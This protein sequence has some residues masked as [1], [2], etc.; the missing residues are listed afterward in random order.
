M[1]KNTLRKLNKI[2]KLIQPKRLKIAEQILI[3]SNVKKYILNKNNG[4]ARIV[5]SLYVQLHHKNWK[6]TTNELKVSRKR[7]IL[8]SV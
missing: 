3:V 6:I 4:T 2:R 7:G 1:N 5:F 8:V